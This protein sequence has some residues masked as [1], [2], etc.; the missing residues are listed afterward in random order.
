MKKILLF[1]AV[2]LLLSCSQPVKEIVLP[3]PEKFIAFLDYN[4]AEDGTEFGTVLVVSRTIR[5]KVLLTFKNIKESITVNPG[6]IKRFNSKIKII[7]GEK[8]KIAASGIT[9]EIPIKYEKYLGLPLGGV[10]TKSAMF[11][12]NT[13]FFATKSKQNFITFYHISKSK[14]GSFGLPDK[15]TVWYAIA[16]KN[17][18]TISDKDGLLILKDFSGKNKEIYYVTTYYYDTDYNF[19]GGFPGWE[20]RYLKQIK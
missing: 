2:I 20:A 9:Q 8:I 7:K 5:G 14:E 12:D 10:E 19:V 6:E 15:D 4:T 11:T 18:S 3:I 16:F 17:K 1:F 13:K